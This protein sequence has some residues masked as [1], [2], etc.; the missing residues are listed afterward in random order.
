MRELDHHRRINGFSYYGFCPNSYS[1]RVKAL[2][3]EF[4]FKAAAKARE[5]EALSMLR[6]IHDQELAALR[7]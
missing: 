5:A 7:W 2:E 4:N 3:D 6:T 1:S